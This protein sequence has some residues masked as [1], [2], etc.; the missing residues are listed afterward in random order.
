MDRVRQILAFPFYA[1]AFIFRLAMAPFILIGQKISPEGDLSRPVDVILSVLICCA[2]LAS[3]P[4]WIIATRTEPSGRLS[5]R[6]IPQGPVGGWTSI[7]PGF[8]EEE[9]VRVKP[10]IRLTACI[11]AERAVRFQL[12]PSIV[13]FPPCGDGGQVD[14]A[15]AD[16]FIDTTVS[17]D[18]TVNGRHQHFVVTLQHYPTSLDEWAFIAGTI[19]IE[20][21]ETQISCAP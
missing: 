18:M 10:Q 13:N 11:F 9:L 2:I 16:N 8:T 14:V 7:K 17:G 1:V 12:E 19:Q 6:L 21:G 4:G 20:G 5:S 15:V 3:A